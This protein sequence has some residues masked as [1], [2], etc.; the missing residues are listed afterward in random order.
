MATRSGVWNRF[1]SDFSFDIPRFSLQD[2]YHSPGLAE[3]VS[4]PSLL[5][6]AIFN[7]AFVGRAQCMSLAGAPAD[8]AVVLT[9]QV[10]AVEREAAALSAALSG[11]RRLRLLLF[12]LVVAVA[13]GITT[14][15]YRLGA[16]VTGDQN[17]QQL[18][19]IAQQRLT[20]NSDA[21]LKHVRTLVDE[22]SPAISQAFSAQVKKDLPR[23]I[24]GMEKERDQLREDLQ[25]EL[26][27]R[28]N[29]H[30]EKLLAQQDHTLK[31]EFPLVKD[32]QLHARMMHN[33][34]RAV[35][36][37]IKKHYVDEMAS[38]LQGIFQTVDSFPP[39]GPPPKGLTLS[40]E[41]VAYAIELFK[42][43]WSQPAVLVSP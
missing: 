42:F 9:E 43:L 4:S 25:T 32:E 28:L 18:L 17:R 34:D 11:G 12:L 13:A 20:D 7:P 6:D 24:Q 41:F 3:A 40:D 14:L 22:T 31:E 39:A 2:P 30:Y 15:F 1:F 10:R 36:R 27:K 23:Y 19:D 37:M 16:R 29:A 33:I 8:D 26:G 21:Y 5:Q 35:Q 38:G